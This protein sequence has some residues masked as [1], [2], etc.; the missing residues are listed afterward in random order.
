[1]RKLLAAAKHYRTDHSNGLDLHFADLSQLNEHLRSLLRV[2]SELV[3]SDLFQHGW[4]AVRDLF[5]RTA[6]DCFHRSL[7]AKPNF[8]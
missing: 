1:M 8:R 4:S 6:V 2:T 5:I 7:R 3:A